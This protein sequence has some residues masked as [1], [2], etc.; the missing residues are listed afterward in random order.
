MAD[1]VPLHPPHMIEPRDLGTGLGSAVAR[2]QPNIRLVSSDGTNIAIHDDGSVEIGAPAVHSDREEKDQRFDDN[3]ALDMEGM[4]LAGLAADTLQGLE[5]D[6]QA[7]SKLIG[8]RNKAI[9]LLGLT[10]EQAASQKTQKRGV[11]KVGNPMLLSACVEYQSS[12][13]GEMLPAA[14]PAKIQD[15]GGADG[16][17]ARD[18]ENDFNYY[19]TTIAREYYPDTDR[20][21]F[22]QAFD[23]SAYKKVYRCPMRQRPVAESIYLPDLVVSQDATDI[24]NAVR[25]SHLTRPTHAEIKRMQHFGRYRDVQLGIPS[26]PPNSAKS[27]EKETQGVSPLS[28]RPQDQPYTNAEIDVYI[29]PADY[30]LPTSSAPS[31]LPLPF[32][33]TVNRD[34]REV[35]AVWRNW[36][37]GDAAFLKR[38]MYVPYDL[39]RGMGFYGLGFSHLLGNQTQALRAAWRLLLDAMMFSSFPGGMKAKGARTSTN[40][41]APGPGEWVDVDIPLDADLSKLAVPLPYKELNAVAIQFI[42]KI[43]QSSENLGAKVKLE[44]GEG[45][46]NVPVGTIMAMIE[47]QTKTMGAVHKRNHKAQGDELLKMRE[48]FAEHPE[49]LW[50]LARKPARR[51]EVAQEFMDLDLVPRSDPNVPSQMHRIMQATALYTMAT[52]PFV[53]QQ[54]AMPIRPV[55]RKA[56]MAINMNDS[57]QLVSPEPP[58]QQ[59]Q[60]DPKA[61]AQ[62]AQAQAKQTQN[63]IAQQKLQETA[64]DRQRQAANDLVEAKERAADRQQESQ[65]EQQKIGLEREK[66]AHEDQQHQREM[67]RDHVQHQQE[68]QQEAQQHSHEMGLEAHKHQTQMGLEQQK[69]EAQVG[70]EQQQQES[71]MAKHEAGLEAEREKTASQQKLDLKKHGGE[72]EQRERESKRERRDFGGSDL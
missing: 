26:P 61:M 7:R 67:Q 12:F 44:I 14:G 72:L 58:P 46:T 30:G 42:E 37:D 21:A 23:G 5:V 47:E 68:M 55:L 3:L 64:E 38:N 1:V 60:M 53:V 63:Q 13:M 56:L 28:Q 22:Y 18:F 4:N 9:D 20:M 32:K 6:E 24:E 35:L 51:W 11:S 49:D 66:M 25:V 2:P 43:Q 16:Q 40:E 50:R 57:D 17:L 19:L 34:S 45:R 29:D 31:G 10:I 59:P 48:L 69:H 15:V 41:I 52:N 39:A 71:D 54:G 27:K 65:I 62:M 8:N 36:K 70:L 33:V